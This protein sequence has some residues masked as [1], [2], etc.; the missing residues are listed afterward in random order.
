VVFGPACPSGRGQAGSGGLRAADWRVIE[1]PSLFARPA[2]W[3]GEGAGERRAAG[4]WRR[5]A[6][7]RVSG[8]RDGKW[9]STVLRVTNSAWAISGLLIPLAASSPTR[10]FVSGCQ[11]LSPVRTGRRG[12]APTDRSSVAARC[13]SRPAPHR[14]ARS[15]P[16]A[17]WLAGC[18]A[19]VGRAAARRRA[20]L[21]ARRA[22][23]AR[24]TQRSTSTACSRSSSPCWPPWSRPRVRSAIPAG[25][26][27]RPAVPP[28][29]H[30]R[31]AAAPG[32]GL[33]PA[34]ASASAER[35]QV[36]GFSRCS[37]W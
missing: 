33:R 3:A 19:L 9:P 21:G 14:Y 10:P 26:A 31:P 18:G 20:R 16:G 27:I 12:L 37:A 29:A 2:A 36:P 6:D 22:P 7:R 25:A 23:A 34:S 1:P 8:R 4:S 15:Q 32:L 30:C 5:E 17:Q 24:R 13:A 11:R 35:Q 28:R